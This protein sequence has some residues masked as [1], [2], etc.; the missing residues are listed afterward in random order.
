VD[1]LAPTIAITFPVNGGRYNNATYNAGCGTAGVG[2]FC[3]T[4]ADAGTGVTQVQVSIQQGAGNYWNGTTFG[5][6]TQVLFAATGTTS[7][8]YA[9]TAAS[10]PANGAYT[11][12][13]RA[14]DGMGTATTATSTITIDRTAPTG[15]NIQTIN[16][17]GGIVGKAEIADTMTWTFSE[18][19]DPATILAGWSGAS[20]NVVLRLN[21]GGAGNDTVTVFNAANSAQLPLGSVSMARTDYVTANVT[22]GASGTPSTMVMSGS[23]VTITLGTVSNAASVGTAAATATMA[24]T[25]SATVLDLAGNACTTTVTNETGVAD[26]DF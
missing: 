18:A 22:F 20:T 15:S 7:W 12:R 25:P 19:V 10:F 2:D 11:I 9:F 3:G 13:A 23:T 5:S 14:T 6:A 21:N 8:T 24:W 17:A 1:T 16:K 26:R 4:S